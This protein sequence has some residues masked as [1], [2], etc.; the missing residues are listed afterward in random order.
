MDLDS[1]SLAR[2][3]PAVAPMRS[4]LRATERP[5]PADERPG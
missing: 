5:A 3:G 1:T 4:D 2:V